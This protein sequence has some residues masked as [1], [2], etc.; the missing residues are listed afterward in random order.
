MYK[1]KSQKKDLNSERQKIEI[2]KNIADHHWMG[3]AVQ[4]IVIIEKQIYFLK[5]NSLSATIN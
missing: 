1:D 2:K 5:V 3:Y 4:K